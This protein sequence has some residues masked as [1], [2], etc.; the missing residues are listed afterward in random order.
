MRRMEPARRSGVK[1][2]K[3]PHVSVRVFWLR[4]RDS[5]PRPRGD[6]PR[7]QPTALSRVIWA[8]RQYTAGRGGCQ[9]DGAPVSPSSGRSNQKVEPAFSLEAKPM[10]PPCA[11]TKWRARERLTP[12]A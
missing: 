6:G 2:R 4:E 8:W 10:S 5:T 1:E 3:D 9:A 7:E 11:C 12:L